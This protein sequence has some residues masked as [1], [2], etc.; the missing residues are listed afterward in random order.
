MVHVVGGFDATAL[1]AEGRTPDGEGDRDDDARI[2]VGP[3]D[4]QNDMSSVLEQQPNQIKS[5]HPTPTR[6]GDGLSSGVR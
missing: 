5:P 4:A 6:R 1:P 2:G 3:V